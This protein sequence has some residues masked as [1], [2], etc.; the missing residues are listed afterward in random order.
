MST[1]SILDNEDKNE[2]NSHAL[3]IFIQGAQGSIPVILGAVPFG[4]LFGTLANSLEL[5][6]LTTAAISLFVFAGSAQFIALGLLAAGAGP[7][8]IIFTTLIVNLRHL[9]YSAAL[10]KWIKPIPRITRAVMAFG[11]T[12]ETFAVVS[13]YCQIKPS[14]DQF[15]WYYLGSM[16]AM[17][18]NWQLCTWIGYSLGASF[19]NINNWGL[20]FAMIVTFTGMVALYLKGNPLENSPMWLCVISSALLSVLTLSLPHNLGLILSAMGGIGLG[21]SAQLLKNRPQPSA[22]GDENE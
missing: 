9:L 7:W 1:S 17:Y 16:V 22:R 11:L 18:G 14:K 13:H 10:V 12:D 3:K 21:Y 2:K 4:I 19:P 15:K 20:E 6:F 8:L 5:S